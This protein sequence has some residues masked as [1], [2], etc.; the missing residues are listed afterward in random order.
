[1]ADPERTRLVVLGDAGVGKSAICKRFLYNS[2]CSK[3]KTTVE[4]LYS[5][6]FN[7]GTSQQLKVDILDTCG[8]PQFPAMRR[9]SIANANAFL[10]VYSI[11]CERSFEM[12]KR[13]FEEVREQR[14][15]YQALPIVVAGNKLDLPADHRRIAVEDASEWLYCELPKMRVKLIE[16]S[17]KENVNVRELFKNLL[18]L[19]RKLNGQEDQSACPLKRRSSAYVSHTK[20]SRRADNAVPAGGAATT[21]GSPATSASGHGREEHQLQQ[22][23][24][25]ERAKPR[26]RSLIRRCS[27]KTKQQIRDTT[28]NGGGSG[29][30]DCNVS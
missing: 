27:R 17:A 18:I 25:P 7:V 13:N 26:S 29:V 12:V 14:E 30:D 20:S 23:K 11:D 19:S 28:A 15:D 2:F 6:E 21:S 3:Y 9:L 24:E 16:C 5:K 8:N 10:F 4:D 22:H 1:M